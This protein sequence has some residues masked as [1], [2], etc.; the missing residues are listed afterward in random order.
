MS[1]PATG[2]SRSSVDV[3]GLP[4]AVFGPRALLWWGTLGFMAVEGMTLV[5]CVACYFYLWRNEAT[6]PP[7][8]TLRP[9]LLWPTITLVVMLASLVPVR[10]ADKAAHRLDLPAVRRWLVVALLFATAFLPLRWMDLLS[11]NCRW[12]TNAYGSISW[13]TAGV[14][15]TLLWLNFFETIGFVAIVFSPSFHDKHFTDVS[16]SCF[17]WYF[18]VLVWV[19]LYATVYL[20]PYLT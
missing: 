10:L 17:Y 7:E 13:I 20:T 8:H 15:A 14:H 5:V 16:E 3:S 1:A 2:L 11:L 9:S 18:M 6:W 19:P 4:T 12:D